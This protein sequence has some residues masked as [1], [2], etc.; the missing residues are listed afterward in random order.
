MFPNVPVFSEQLNPSLYLRER[1]ALKK[2]IITKVRPHLILYS[3]VSPRKKLGNF[4][5]IT[6]VVVEGPGAL[7]AC[8]QIP[9]NLPVFRVF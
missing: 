3:A 4:G 9:V 6:W 1:R 2:P 7:I 8:M 5:K